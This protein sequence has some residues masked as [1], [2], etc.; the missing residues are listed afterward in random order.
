MAPSSS[1]R[2]WFRRSMTRW[3]PFMVSSS[4]WLSRSRAV[5]QAGKGLLEQFQTGAHSRGK[6]SGGGGRRVVVPFVRDNI[7]AAA[8]PFTHDRRVLN[9]DAAHMRKAA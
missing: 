6:G 5:S 1:F 4:G 2:A 3:S 7:D 9:D 8:R